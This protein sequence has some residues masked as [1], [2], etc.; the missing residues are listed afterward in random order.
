M[1]FLNGKIRHDF[2]LKFDLGELG[3]TIE[4]NKD[5]K[6]GDWVTVSYDDDVFPG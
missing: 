4:N 1:D 3:A 2:E 6:I 5:I